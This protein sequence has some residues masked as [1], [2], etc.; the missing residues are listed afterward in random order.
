MRRLSW[1]D[2][3]HIAA[4]LAA[5]PALASAVAAAPAIKQIA[6]LDVAVWQPAN[7]GTTHPLVL[8][9]HGWSGCKTQSG[10]LMEALAAEG[11]LVM[12]PDHRDHGCVTR[13]RL[14]FSVPPEL[15]NPAGWKDDRFADRGED[16]EDL[17]T[18]VRSH[19]DYAAQI[20]PGRIALVGHSLGGYTVLGLAGAWPG[21]KLDD[22]A[23][24]VALA[25]YAGTFEKAGEL[26]EVETPMLFEAGEA[27]IISERP[28]VKAVF[29][30]AK[31]PRC[32]VVYPGAGHLAWVDAAELPAELSGLAQPQ[33]HEQIAAAAVAFLDEVFEGR[34]VGSVVKVAEP[35]ATCE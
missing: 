35:S 3:A 17:L 9:S 12:A 18:A 5:I 16:I 23:A 29:E 15:A 13:L 27:D 25:P 34:R 31:A 22:I 24:V 26:D 32:M 4:A 7:D 28:M 19:A 20:D 8:F 1:Q 6:G 10:H 11:M 30:R 14:R 21:W 2:F 33:F